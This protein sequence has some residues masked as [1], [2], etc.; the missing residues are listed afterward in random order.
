LRSVEIAVV[1]LL[2]AHV[3]H[4]VEEAK[5]GFRSKLPLGE[6][7]EPIFWLLNAVGFV[8]AI[9]VVYMCFAGVSLGVTA[10]WVYA[11]VMVINGLVHIGMMI[12]SRGYFPGGYS[13]VLVLMAAVNVI[14]Q[15]S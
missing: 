2:V 1:L 15:L 12:Y 11:V 13:A 6:M 10:A 8:L 4:V 7:P 3:L 9:A 5:T 14:F